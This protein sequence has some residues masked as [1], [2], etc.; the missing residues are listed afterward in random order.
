MSALATTTSPQGKPL[1]IAF[2]HQARVGKD[3]ACA[4]LEERYGG[5]TLRFASKLYTIA[6]GIQKELGKP[7]EK[8]VKLLQ[9]LGEGL[10]QT[11]NENIWAQTLFDSIEECPGNI[12]VSDLRYKNEFAGLKKRG[13]TLVKIEKKNRLVDR[14]PMHRSEI[15]LVDANFDYVIRND[16][17]ITEFHAMLDQLVLTLINQ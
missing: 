17:S 2:G 9:L 13:F 12:F 10:R 4:Y 5:I 8:D 1:K 14:D 6:E 15:D 3:T 16:G 11:Y 7:I